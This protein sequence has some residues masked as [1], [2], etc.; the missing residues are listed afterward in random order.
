MAHARRA[1]RVAELLSAAEAE[2]A[3]SLSDDGELS[4]WLSRLTD[5]LHR[6]R[7]GRQGLTLDQTGNEP[8]TSA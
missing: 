3:A 8:I 6:H 5:I 7:P 1:V 2:L 4:R